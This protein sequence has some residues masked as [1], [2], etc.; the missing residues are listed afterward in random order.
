LR[1]PLG[2]SPTVTRQGGV[3]AR[4]GVAAW[5]PPKEEEGGKKKGKRKGEKGKGKKE[6]GKIEKGKIREENRKGI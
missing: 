3:A 5:N 2:R 1:G 4:R 6:K